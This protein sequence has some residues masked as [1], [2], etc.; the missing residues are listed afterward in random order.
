MHWMRRDSPSV[1][2][3]V[4]YCTQQSLQN[5]CAGHS[6]VAAAAGT[7]HRQ[8]LH[9]SLPDGGAQADCGGADGSAEP[10][11]ARVKQ[12]SASSA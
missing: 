11:P 3:I 8:V 7:S 1:I 2:F 6:A 10:K 5:T 9:A 12:A 4:R